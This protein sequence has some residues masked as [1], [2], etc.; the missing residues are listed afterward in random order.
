MRRGE[1]AAVD[2]SPPPARVRSALAPAPARTT[3]GGNQ[4]HA[5]PI[6]PPKRPERTR[7]AY[8]DRRRFVAGSTAALAAAPVL[9][10]AQPAAPA[11]PPPAAP[12][13]SFDAGTVAR[14]AQKLAAESYQEPDRSLPK[15]LQNLG[16]DAYRDIRFRP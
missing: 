9:A 1:P 5:A 8:L 15:E 4:K 6:S 7:T 3:C 13:D 11:A 14:L 10:R 12:P 16:Y 2:R